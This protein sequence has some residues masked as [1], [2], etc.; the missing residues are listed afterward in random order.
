MSTPKVFCVALALTQQWGCAESPTFLAKRAM[1]D[2]TTPVC[3][4]EQG[5]SA[6][7]RAA[8][9]WVVND[10]GLPIRIATDDV[11]ETYNG[12]P[13]QDPR[14][15]VRVTKEPLGG[16]KYKILVATSCAYDYGCIP[17]RWNAA[18]DFN[19]TV[20]AARP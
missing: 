11:I 4:G 14:L 9:H 1:I 15:I 12:W 19:R 2:E 3:V 7:W 6:K 8:R 17:D 13:S 20:G 5:C 18:L 10:A 16:G